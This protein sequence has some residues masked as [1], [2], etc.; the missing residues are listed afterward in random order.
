MGTKSNPGAYDCYANA[1]PDE[2]MFVLLAR[3]KHAPTLVWLW[4]TLRELDQEDPAKVA[5]ARECV[6]AMCDWQKAHGRAAVGTGQAA[7]AAVLELIRA[8]NYSIRGA[9]NEATSDAQMRLF[10]AETLFEGAGSANGAA[11]TPDAGGV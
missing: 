5:E 4:A 8:A 7:L 6:N 11:T 10:L 1:E 9:T 2:P 3:D